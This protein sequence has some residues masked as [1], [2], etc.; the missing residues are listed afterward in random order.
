MT[1]FHSS[2]S[3]IFTKQK[4]NNTDY[5]YYSPALSGGSWATEEGMS[6][7]S[8]SEAASTKYRVVKIARSFSQEVL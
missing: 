2:R 5:H 3:F 6:D 1:Y 4:V 7:A 8:K